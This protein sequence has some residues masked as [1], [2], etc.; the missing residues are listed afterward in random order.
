MKKNYSEF[1]KDKQKRTLT[2]KGYKFIWK[3]IDIVAGQN[4]LNRYSKELKHL[5]DK[6]T[7]LLTHL[8]IDQEKTINE[9]KEMIKNR[10]LL[11]TNSKK[12]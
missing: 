10:T 4:N 7:T 3:C 5:K 12:Q 1:I 6:L 8:I 2:A 11:I 9:I